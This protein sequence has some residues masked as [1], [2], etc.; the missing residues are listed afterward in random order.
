MTVVLELARAREYFFQPF[1][2]MRSFV[3]SRPRALTW[4][5]FQL[6]VSSRF[7]WEKNRWRFRHL[8]RSSGI[9]TNREQWFATSAIREQRELKILKIFA[10]GPSSTCRL[11]V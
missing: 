8:G 2:N 9:P 6:R 11:C 5:V 7:V 10:G 4:G 3:R 1:E